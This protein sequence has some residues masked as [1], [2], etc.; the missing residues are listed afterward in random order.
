[1]ALTHPQIHCKQIITEDIVLTYPKY[2]DGQHIDLRI[3]I[4]INHFYFLLKIQ[5]LIV[6]LKKSYLINI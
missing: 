6:C 4:C 2:L 3:L 1:M 5:N